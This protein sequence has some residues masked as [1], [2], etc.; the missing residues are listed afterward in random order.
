MSEFK[1]QE[2]YERLNVRVTT[3]G[4]KKI[5]LTDV[6][7]WVAL[8]EEEYK[9]YKFD[10]L[11]EELFKKLEENK[12]IIT[13]SNYDKIKTK[14][15][16]FNWTIGNG[17]SLQILV[18]TLR[19]NFTCKYCYALRRN[20]DEE[21]F[22][23]T[24]EIADKS[25]DFIFQ[26]PAENMVIEFTGGEPLLRF[27][28]IKRVVLRAKEINKK[29]NKTLSF[30]IV[31]NGYYLDDEKFKFLK[32]NK[33]GICLSLDGPKELHDFHRVITKN[34]KMS[35][36]D[37]V[38]KLL[39]KYRLE[40][41]YER[42]FAIPV[43]TKYSFDKY[44]EIVKEYVRLGLPQFRFKYVTYFGFAS[45][46]WDKLFYTPEEFL[47]NWK[48]VIELII[49]LNKKGIK[50]KEELS[51]QILMKMFGDQDPGYAEL[52]KPCGAFIGQLLYNYDGNIF[53]CDE[54]RTLNDE[55]LIGNVNENTYSDL[56]KKNLCKALVS[57]STLLSFNCDN[58]PW[59]SYCG[60]C[61]VEN[62]KMN[63]SLIV[64][65]PSTHRCKIH[66]GMFEF[67]FDKIV[68][69]DDA[70]YLKNWLRIDNKIPEEIPTDKELDKI[71][72]EL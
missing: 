32:E 5:L 6:P 48:K 70:K 2:D 38:V 53:T 11:D 54:S 44:K 31:T 62:Y 35:S 58:C 1:L 56:S 26:S 14:F 50:I 65:I 57:N 45:S 17:T 18:P 34:P 16:N 15:K 64:N 42:T 23:M 63:G 55:F 72:S 28:M 29:Y 13:K 49:K 51:T 9:K 67:L 22:D 30:A 19:C 39:K 47:E 69:S 27:D 33:I 24:E 60:I 40:E 61:P 71:F 20:E 46:S 59:F 4:D 3:L 52:S 7:S 10:D 8:S 43:I 21:G 66:K 25:V 41:K 37:N 68:N 36:Y 12:I